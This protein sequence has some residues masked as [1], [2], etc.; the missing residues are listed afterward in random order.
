MDQHGGRRKERSTWKLRQHHVEEFAFSYR[1]LSRVQLQM[2]NEK[3]KKRNRS[4]L[5][6]LTAEKK[7]VHK[8]F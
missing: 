2:Q 6:Y 1:Q 4:F 5:T 3:R 8:Y 7:T